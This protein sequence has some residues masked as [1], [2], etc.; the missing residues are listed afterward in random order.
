MT[1]YSQV[2]E[3]LKKQ[4]KLKQFVPGDKLPKEVDLS[5]QLGVSRKT[6]RSALDQLEQ[7]GLIVRRKHSGTV[8]T[9]NAAELVKVNL[10]I[11]VVVNLSGGVAGDPLLNAYGLGNQTNEFQ[12]LLHHFLQ[13]GMN[14]Q[15]LKE[16]DDAF[17]DMDGVMVMNLNDSKDI[18]MKIA[19]AGKPH[20]TMESR[21]DYPGVNTVMADDEQAAYD[22][23]NELIEA[24][25]RRIAFIGGKLNRPKLDT[26]FR[27]RTRGFMRACHDKRIEME[28][29]WIFNVE[30]YEGS[31]VDMAELLEDYPGRTRD[32][33]AVVCAIGHSVLELEKMRRICGEKMFPQIELRCVDLH[34]FDASPGVLKTLEHY[35][36][37][38]KP[39][40]QVADMAHRKLLEWIGNDSF[41]PGCFKVPYI[42]HIPN[43]ETE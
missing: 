9:E 22:C 36:G 43:Q 21:L 1:I 13:D 19:D 20:I 10:K 2:S 3:K 29:A 30:H 37:F 35:R 26:G 41:Q 24:G 17:M 32:C 5:E 14:V 11:G 6:L 39:H 34:P 8:I 18:L 27:R 25:H 12:M 15:L 16:D 33:S 4:I 38:T 40:R 42:K 31:G 28:P 23:T 7:E